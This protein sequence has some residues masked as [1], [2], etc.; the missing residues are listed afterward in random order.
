MISNFKVILFD[1]YGTLLVFD[2]FDRAN[3]E[4]EQTFLDAVAKRSALNLQ[5]VQTIC[6]NILVCN[7]EKELSG[8]LT[9]YETKILNEF[10]KYNLCFSEDEIKQLADTSLEKWQSF[11]RPADDVFLVLE[12]LAKKYKVGLITNFDH[13][14]HVR[15]VL[16]STGLEKCF[17]M[18]WI[19][20]EAGCQKPDP[21]IFQM[22]IEYLNVLPE[23]TIYVGDNI[24][25]DVK[26]SCAAG[27]IPVLIDR[28]SKSN[29]YNNHDAELQF[30][31]VKNITVIKSLS[32]L[33]SL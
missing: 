7:V 11:I 32:E 19:S 31:Q 28:N 27:M 12:E 24:V 5:I 33:L 1:L 2:N 22:A 8:G 9:T 10:E 29:M 26:G 25:D 30:P 14:R 23:E 20:D 4:W 13:G 16:A 21:K 17:D 3:R 6:K 15:K 18:V